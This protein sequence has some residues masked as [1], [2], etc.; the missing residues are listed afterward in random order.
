MHVVQ[1]LID[2]HVHMLIGGS[3][4]QQIDL[5]GIASKADFVA[6]VQNAAGGLAVLCSILHSVLLHRGNTKFLF[7]FL[8]GKNCVCCKPQCTL[9]NC[10]IMDLKDAAIKLTDRS[11]RVHTA[12][13]CLRSPAFPLSASACFN[14]CLPS[15]PQYVMGCATEAAF[16]QMH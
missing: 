13:H 14:S 8:L 2:A 3:S 10:R 9:R 5:R 12:G 11:E 6:A 16:F 15:L 4:L 1:G 7:C